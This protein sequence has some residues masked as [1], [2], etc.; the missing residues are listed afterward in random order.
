MEEEKWRIP[1][2]EPRRM[3]IVYKEIV[4]ESMNPWMHSI[5]IPS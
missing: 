5:A 2:S 1:G 3:R 4:Y